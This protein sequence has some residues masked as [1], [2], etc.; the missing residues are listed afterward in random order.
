MKISRA[1]YTASCTFQKFQ[2]WTCENRPRLVESDVKKYQYVKMKA[3][4]GNLWKV[5]EILVCAELVFSFF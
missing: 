2:K 4:V 5:S 1:S 3:H